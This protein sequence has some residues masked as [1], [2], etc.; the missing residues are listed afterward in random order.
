MTTM[1]ASEMARIMGRKGGRARASRLSAERRSEIAR[2]GGKARRE[3]F[4]IAKRIQSNFDHLA[5]IRE[6]RNAGK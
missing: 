1:T 2:M 6:L 5:A 4:E 3:S